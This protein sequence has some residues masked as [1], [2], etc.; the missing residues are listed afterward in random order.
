MKSRLFLALLGIFLIGVAVGIIFTLVNPQFVE[1]LFA[2]LKQVFGQK[3]GT[4]AFDSFKMFWVVFLNN[5]RVAVLAT[6]G[7]I[8]F[9][10]VPIGILFFNGFIVGIVVEYHYLQG[11]SMSRIILS[12]V[13][14]GIV[15]I[16][17]FAL[18]SLGGIEWYMEIIKGE[19]G[20]GERFKAGFRKAMRMLA[21]SIVLLL[22]AALIE[23]FITP[24]LAG[25]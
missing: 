21:F 7:G 18:A 9:G 24:K 16:P 2:N 20:I 23:A 3:F 1:N 13:P 10:I 5:S 6:F 22:I 8:L 4:G 11:M 19:G 12:I 14:H 15:E 17:A 25:I